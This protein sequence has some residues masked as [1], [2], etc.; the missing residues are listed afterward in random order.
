AVHAPVLGQLRGGARD[1]SL[2][3]LELGLEA[4]QECEGVGRSA[5]EADY[6]FAAV[7]PA[8][9][10]SVVFHNDLAHR[11]LAVAADVGRPL[12]PHRQD[13]GRTDLLGTRRGHAEISSMQERITLEVEKRTLSSML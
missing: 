6:D 2:K 11:D 12:M 7:Q 9:L 10:V 5:G 4:F 13:G 8:N 3:V 1:A